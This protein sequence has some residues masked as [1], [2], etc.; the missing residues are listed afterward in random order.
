MIMLDSYMD[1]I[2][3][4]RY[5]LLTDERLFQE[6]MKCSISNDFFSEETE[7]KSTYDQNKNYSCFA[8]QINLTDSYYRLQ[9]VYKFKRSFSLN[10]TEFYVNDAVSAE[11]NG[12]II[13]FIHFSLEFALKIYIEK[14]V[15]NQIFGP[16]TNLLIDSIV[17]LYK[18][19]NTTRMYINN[20]ISTI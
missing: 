6:P 4:D 2:I 12:K 10:L 7:G 19:G 11:D 13:N 5:R 9:E 16:K 17:L 20:L 14:A 8:K 18:G 15:L 1:D 3:K